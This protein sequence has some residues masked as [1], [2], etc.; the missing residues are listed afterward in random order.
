MA[1]S[2]AMSTYWPEAGAL[3][4]A[5]RCEDPDHGEEPGT[6]VAEPPATGSTRGGSSPRRE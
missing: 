5:Q 4:V 1:S 3:A 2:I 6:D